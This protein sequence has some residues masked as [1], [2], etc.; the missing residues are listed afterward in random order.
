MAGGSA[1]SGPANLHG[2]GEF[3]CLLINGKRFE[4]LPLNTYGTNETELVE[5]YPSKAEVTGTVEDKMRPP[6]Q[7][8]SDGTHPTWYV[9]WL[10]GAK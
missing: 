8:S 5:I 4:H 6:C 2:A 1:K 10:K 9:I 7:K 3:Q